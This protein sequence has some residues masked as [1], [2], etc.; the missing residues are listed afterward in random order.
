MGTQAESS[1]TCCS[2]GP[3]HFLD[4]TNV[5]LPSICDIILAKENGAELMAVSMEG[6]TEE[7][8]TRV[9]HGALC[10]A[11]KDCRKK[12]NTIVEGLIGSLPSAE[13]GAVDILGG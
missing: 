3:S 11:P 2:W 6:V 1:V 12:K 9:F 4:A 5:A 8:V 7:N 10:Q 13:I